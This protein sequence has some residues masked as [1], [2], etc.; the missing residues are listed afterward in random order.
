M[1]CATL[2][3]QQATMATTQLMPATGYHVIWPSQEERT[4]FHP[5][6]MRWVVVTDEN[7]KR[8]LR[9]QWSAADRPELRRS[10]GV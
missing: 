9:M 7:G 2:T 1:C 5:L 4:E 3:I 8:E 6:H 10:A